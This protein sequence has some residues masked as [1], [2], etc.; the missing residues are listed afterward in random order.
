MISMVTPAH[1]CG[2]TESCHMSLFAIRDGKVDC[3][4]N[5]V[6]PPRL[7]PFM[8]EL[9]DAGFQKNGVV[10]CCTFFDESIVNYFPAREMDGL[11]AASIIS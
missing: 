3:V 8:Q 9:Y 2:G 1:Q 10:V 6:V 11:I 4:L 5:T 7:Q